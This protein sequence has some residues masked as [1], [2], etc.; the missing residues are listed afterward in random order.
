MSRKAPIVS[1]ILPTFNR[2]DLVLESIHSILGQS[3]K[4]YE[5]IV[6]DD[7]S[8]D[9][10]RE[11]LSPLVKEGLLKYAYQEN[12]GLPAA[13][14]HGIRLAK[15][16]L[17]TFLDS[18]DLYLP[19]KLEKQAAFF[20]E[21]PEA[22]MLQCWFSKFNEQ[23]EDLGVRDTSWFEGQIYPDILMQW[24]VLMAVSCVMMRREVL[25]KVGPFNES[26]LWGEDLDL[27]RRVAR[28][29]P[30]HMIPESL[31][32]VRV[33]ASNM[34]SDK[35]QG[36][37]HFAVVLEE[38]FIDDPSTSPDF[39]K[40][41]WASMYTNVAHNLLGQGPREHMGLVRD[42]SLKALA[43]QPLNLGALIALPAS[44]L[45]FRLRMWLV[46]QLR[47]LRYPAK[48]S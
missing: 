3:Y 17:I 4:N 2:A 26:L 46:K 16:S 31:V 20:E 9:N 8:V 30:Y 7:G 19:E 25:D 29:F 47:K 1:V 36:A 15:G 14:N 37:K 23:S 11:Q 10:T 40:K 12:S 18:D 35:S 42:Y 34:S 13:R 24:S 6:I 32:K 28:H 45:P 41:A 43:F 22:Q 21:H 27:W 44:L 38:A 5:L 39:Q 33:H 48:H